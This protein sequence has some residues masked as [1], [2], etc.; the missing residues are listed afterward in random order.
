M[1]ELKPCPVCGGD[2]QKF[3]GY[4]Y[5]KVGCKNEDCNYSFKPQYPNDWNNRPY[6]NK[7][8]ADAV[9][10]FSDAL[11][12]SLRYEV[13][14]LQDIDAIEE[15]IDSVTENKLEIGDL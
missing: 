2:A 14:G 3:F 13:E 1:N 7:L 11:C 4:Y 15:F 6:E 5:G 8:K 10:R 12:H 9:H